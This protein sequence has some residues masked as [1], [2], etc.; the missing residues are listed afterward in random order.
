MLRLNHT[1]PIQVGM[2]QPPPPRNGQQVSGLSLVDTRDLGECR[3]NATFVYTNSAVP[4]PAKMAVSCRCL[5]T[6]GS[7]NGV[8][9]G[10]CSLVGAIRR[11]PNRDRPVPGRVIEHRSCG[12]GCGGV[13][14]LGN[15]HIHQPYFRT[16]TRVCERKVRQFRVQGRRPR[17]F[18]RSG[19]RT[20][21]RHWHAASS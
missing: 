9:L 11:S 13:D 5:S 19:I 6:Q 12:H 10:E 17:T 3:G 21:G 2:W 8:Y 1:A 20:L 14:Q 4:V 7:V 16:S 15:C 18:G